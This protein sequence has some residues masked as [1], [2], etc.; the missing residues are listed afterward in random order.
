MERNIHKFASKL[1]PHHQTAECSTEVSLADD[2]KSP[3]ESSTVS[4]NHAIAPRVEGRIVDVA[5][6]PKEG[7]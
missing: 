3:G 6:A 7:V 1:L 4:V 2:P 5:P